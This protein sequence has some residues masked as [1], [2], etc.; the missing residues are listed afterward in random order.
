VVLVEG[1]SDVAAV[2]AAARARGVDLAIAGIDVI[3]VG[4]YGGFAPAAAAVEASGITLLCDAAEASWVARALPRVPL[5]VC[6]VD[7]EDELIR[8]LGLPAVER[9]IAAE[10][11]GGLLAGFRRQPAQQGRAP[12]A[13]VRRFLGT[14]SGRKIRYAGLLAAALAP[15]AVPAPIAGALTDACRGASGP[16]DRDDTPP[17]RP[18]R[19]RF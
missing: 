7:L 9:I 15:E 13:Q 5:H 2:E 17:S 14:K 18:H 4:G 12:V 19:L 16:P 1:R 10:G 11:D 8:A 3:A 6:D